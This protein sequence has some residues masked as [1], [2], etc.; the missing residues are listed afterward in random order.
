MFKKDR[1][2]TTLSGFA[3]ITGGLATIFTKG[4]LVG[5]ITAVI[6]GFGLILA[7]DAGAPTV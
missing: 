5:G 2:K 3:A 6:A 1:W 7:H 4:D